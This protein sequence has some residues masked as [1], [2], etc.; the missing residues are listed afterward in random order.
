MTINRRRFLERGAMAG[1]ALAALGPFHAL[2]AS[3]SNGRSFQS[4][5]YG[6]LMRKGA[7]WLPID[8]N[9]QVLSVQGT[10]MSDGRPTPGIFDGMAAFPGTD[11]GTILIRNHENRERAGEQKVI[12]D[13]CHDYDPLATGGVTKLEIS[14]QRA[15]KD[16][17]TGQQLYS[18]NVI[19]DFAIL[20]GTSTN[21]GGGIRHPHTWI[22]CEE[23]VKRSTNG[24][25][26]GYIFEVDA[27]SDRALPAIPVCQAGR[28]AH[29]AAA[30]RAG[31]IYMTEDRS[32]SPDPVAARRLIGSCFYRYR[33]AP[34]ATPLASTNGP[35]EALKLRNEFQANMDEGRVVGAPYPVEWVAV[36][37]P[38][39]DDDTD[40][41]RDRAPGH[42]PNRIQAQDRG[43]AFFDRLEGMWIGNGEGKI[44]FTATAGGVRKLGQVWEYDPGREI[45]TL[46]YESTDSARLQ[47]PDNI[48]VVP[49][50][51]DILI[52]EDGPGNQ[53]IRGVTQE[54]EIFDFARTTA[55]R[56]EFCGA[57]FAPDGQTLYLNQQGQRGSLP[58]GPQDG[59]AVTY[60]IY[61]PFEKRRSGLKKY[62]W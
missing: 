4:E 15:G 28:R 59:G 43:A 34:S 32:I 6:P 26:H 60:A 20:S 33:P 41:R 57:C 17:V 25:K 3:G 35:L 24:I 50:T 46:I 22:T 39:H 56:T 7:L 47:N 2:G 5:G 19:R 9:Y 27:R 21:C 13:P 54:G 44:Y 49:S 40:D 36:D 8:F 42:T 61:G 12:T 30:E 18:Y 16:S 23:V 58:R 11:G 51:Q 37:E 48:V 29:E 62:L 38:D 52:C 55:N 53:C 45:I 10:V 1:G 31:I 14:R